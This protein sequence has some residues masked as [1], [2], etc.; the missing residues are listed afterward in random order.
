[1]TT[2]QLPDRALGL[3]ARLIARPDADSKPAA[4]PC[5]RHRHVQAIGGTRSL[6]LCQAEV[7]Q[8]ADVRTASIGF[9]V[10]DA[11]AMPPGQHQPQVGQLTQTHPHCFGRPLG[12]QP[13]FGPD[14]FYF[15]SPVAA[16]ASRRAEERGNRG[17]GCATLLAVMSSG[18]DGGG[19][20][21]D[22][23]SHA[24]RF[25]LVPAPAMKGQGYL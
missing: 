5:S 11:D 10:A 21:L 13:Q 20:L 2:D 15:F 19:R 1:M 8:P 17:S 23:L 12:A 14:L 6:L 7:A 22:N 3:R 24:L 16:G 18:R 25:K 4:Y 9:R